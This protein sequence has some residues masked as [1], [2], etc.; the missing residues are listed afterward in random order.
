[1]STIA[2]IGVG[3]MGGPM[4][5]NLLKAQD[6]VRAFDVSPAAIKPIVDAGA[7]QARLRWKRCPVRTSSSRCFPPVRMSVLSIWRTPAS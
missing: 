1:M 6:Q 2:F 4:A 5:R 3:N 7:K